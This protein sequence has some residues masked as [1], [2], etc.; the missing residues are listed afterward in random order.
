LD[1]KGQFHFETRCKQGCKKQGTHF[2][3]ASRMVVSGPL[4]L[5]VLARGIIAVDCAHSQHRGTHPQISILK[6]SKVKVSDDLRQHFPELQ[7]IS[8]EMPAAPKLFPLGEPAAKK[9]HPA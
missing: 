9:I 8:N 1:E 7:G 5:S 4:Q 6:G 2:C 3:G